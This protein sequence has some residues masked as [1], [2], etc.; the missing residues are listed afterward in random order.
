[1]HSTE[2]GFDFA[3]SLGATHVLDY[4]FIGPEVGAG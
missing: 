4:E 3:G 1:M 2:A